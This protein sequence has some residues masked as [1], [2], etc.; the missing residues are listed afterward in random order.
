M[1]RDSDLRLTEAL[2]FGVE[3]LTANRDGY[4][5]KRQRTLL[6]LERSNWRWLYL[7]ILILT[8]IVFALVIWDGYRIG[9]TPS[10][11]LGIICFASIVACISFMYAYSKWK[12]V[13]KD[14]LKGNVESIEGKAHLE[15]YRA[16]DGM[17]YFI[18][19]GNS[20]FNIGRSAFQEF[21]NNEDYRVYYSPHARRIISAEKIKS[22]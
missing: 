8:P 1:E 12:A 14:L 15:G 19:F 6:S 9:D 4:V 16:R 7:A 13:D 3:E 10:S 5:T 20:K 11:R 2:G 18:K 21:M 17:K 22:S